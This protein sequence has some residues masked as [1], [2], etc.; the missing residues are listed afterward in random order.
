MNDFVRQLRA[1]ITEL[2]QKLTEWSKLKEERDQVA[3]L[4]AW[5]EENEATVPLFKAAELPALRVVP[6]NRASLSKRFQPRDDSKTT[7]IA[8]FARTFLDD[9]GVQKIAFTDFANA[10][11]GPLH[12]GGVHW[13]E[14]AR[15]AIKRAGA[16]FGVAYVNGM[17]V[18]NDRTPMQV[19]A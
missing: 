8:K 16:R 19:T 3:A 1:K 6:A 14:A 9:L 17:I 7:Q 10:L 4:L 12:G 13:R 2:D 5:Y 15:T 11:P 18:K